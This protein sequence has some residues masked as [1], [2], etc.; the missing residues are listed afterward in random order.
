MV[1]R[2]LSAEA[3]RKRVE[4]A[5][6]I[7]RLSGVRFEKNAKFVFL[8]DQYGDLR[9]WDA[10]EMAFKTS[11]KAYWGV[12][13]GLKRRGGACPKS[14]FPRVCG[15]P[16]RRQKQLSPETLLERL[17]NIHLLKEVQDDKMGEP[18]ISFN[19]FC[20]Q[21]DAPSPEYRA[22]II[23]ENI[24]IRAIADW[25]R[26][27]GLGSYGKFALRNGDT[28]SVVSGITWD[29]T[30]PS[31][32]RPLVSAPNGDI[33][34]G[35]FVCDVNLGHQITDEEVELF[36]RKYDMAA[37]PRNVAPIMGFLVADGFVSSAYDKARAAGIVA[38]TTANL[39]GAEISKALNDLIKLLSDTGRTAAVN[40][41]HLE[42]VMNRLSKIEGASDNLRGSLFELV[43]GNLLVGV[44]EGYL[45]TGRKIGLDVV[46]DLAS[47]NKAIIVE[48]K[49]KIPGAMVSLKDVE[50]WYGNRVPLINETIRRHEINYVDRKIEF[51]I[52]T[53]GTFHPAALEWLGQQQTEFESYSVAWRD[54]A[55]IKQYSLNEKVSK[56]T[57]DILKEHYFKN[58]KTSIIS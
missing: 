20:Y 31:Y 4:R 56:H 55:Y 40:P 6:G 38:T 24:A 11:G 49:A 32:I 37:S 1:E 23:A 19:P 3:A 50:R 2:G 33:R 22:I 57:R 27:L 43:V 42:N 17:T 48:C 35:F 12:M 13:V 29:I 5:G 28:P 34:P 18:W 46:V 14:L 21:R 8:E 47:E 45:T 16:T 9:F 7:K 25:A 44:T 52:W 15:A 51:E 26:K 53:N 10:L 30:A 41:E 39:F 58:P 54:G 36:I